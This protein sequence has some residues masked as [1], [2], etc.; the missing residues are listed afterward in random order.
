[1]FKQHGSIIREGKITSVR[2]FPIGIDTQGHADIAASSGVR[3]A[4]VQ[5]KARIGPNRRV[6]IGIDRIDYT[7]GIAERIRALGILFEENPE[8]REKLVFIQ[9]GVPSRCEIPE[10]QVLSDEIDCAIASVNSRWGTESWQPIVFVKRNLPAEEMIALHKLADFCLV[11]S[12][13]DGMN[14]VAKEFVASRSDLD[15][16]LVLSRF[17]GASEEL[18][19]ALLINPFSED[20]IAQAVLAA[21]TMPA[22]ERN[23]RMSRMRVAVE[24]NNIYHW[25][26]DILSALIQIEAGSLRMP[27]VPLERLV[28]AGRIAEASFA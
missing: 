25:A 27:A 10:Y 13:H 7:K 12:L 17:A 4:T 9:V 22:A 5:W 18:N 6:G 11:T 3:A 14:L 16:V 19:S 20:E 26:S 24:Q 1:V 28:G 21:L 2:H 23:R 15:G 8:W